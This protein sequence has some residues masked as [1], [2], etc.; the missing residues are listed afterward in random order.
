MAWPPVRPARAL[1]ALILALAA[2]AS[3]TKPAPPASDGGALV[4]VDSARSPAPPAEAGGAEAPPEEPPA[5]EE[6][7]GDE[8]KPEVN[9]EPCQVKGRELTRVTESNR[10]CD[11][12]ECNHSETITVE[13]KD[14]AELLSASNE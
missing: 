9:R 13:D 12:L 7:D 14:G 6:N 8:D 11:G 2:C 3:R 4:R 5:E 10:I 1:L